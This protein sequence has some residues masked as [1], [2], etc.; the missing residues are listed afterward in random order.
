[1]APNN[2]D[3]TTQ[4]VPS[5]T[6]ITLTN[7]NECYEVVLPRTCGMVAFSPITKAAFVGYTSAANLG[8]N[9]HPLPVGSVSQWPVFAGKDPKSRA[10]I[11]LQTADAGTVVTVSLLPRT[12]IFVE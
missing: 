8:N 2:V 7:A 1:M 12:G 9:K 11:C 5:T 3:L 10:R 6:A 4:A